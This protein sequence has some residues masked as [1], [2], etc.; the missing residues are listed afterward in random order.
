MWTNTR[1]IVSLVLGV[2]FLVLVIGQMVELM[3]ARSRGRSYSFIPIL[4]AVLGVTACLVAPWRGSVYAI[5]LELILD[6]TPLMIVVVALRGGF[7][8]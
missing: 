8:K 1:A 6:P 4:P 2:A 3:S 5:P 7:S